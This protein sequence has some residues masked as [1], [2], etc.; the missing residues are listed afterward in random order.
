[1]SPINAKL[2]ERG[3]S[4]GAVSDPRYRGGSQKHG[5]PNTIRQKELCMNVLTYLVLLADVLLW[6]CKRWVGRWVMCCMR[7]CF[8]TTAVLPR[9]LVDTGGWTGGWLTPFLI[10]W[11]YHSVEGHGRA[12]HIYLMG[13]PR[14]RDRA[15]TTAHGGTR[16]YR[17][18]DV[19]QPQTR[20]AG[21]VETSRPR[22]PIWRGS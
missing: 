8:S 1:M 14:P 18:K 11:W 13:P 5:S 6:C 4:K 15:T 17:R 12:F 9:Y 10:H 7:C 16:S 21:R 2:G 22:S 3:A 20:Q 19:L